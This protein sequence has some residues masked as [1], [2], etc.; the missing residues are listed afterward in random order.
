M[1]AVLTIVFYLPFWEGGSVSDLLGV[2]RRSQLFTTSLPSL[3]R[4]LA[5]PGLGEVEASRVIARAA[6][7]ALALWMGVTS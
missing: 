7:G 4:E 6:M 5:A 1:G 3:L 2:G